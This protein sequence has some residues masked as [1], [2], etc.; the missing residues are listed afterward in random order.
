MKIGGIQKF[1]LID[2]PGK[3]SCVVFTQGCNFRCGYCHNP[4]LVLPEFF[5]NTI[6]EKIVF[7]YLLNRKNKIEGVV[8][9]GGEPTIHNDLPGFIKKIKMLG[10]NV[11]LD[12]NGGNP[13]MLKI[14]FE[15]KLL[16][17]VAMDV[18]TEL[19]NYS[20]LCGVNINSKAISESISLIKNSSV[21]RQ[22]RITLLK[23]IHDVDQITK[24]ENT[25][26]IKLH[27]QYFHFTTALL[28][29]KYNQSNS[30][31]L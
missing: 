5:E 15:E 29:K 20:K 10:F 14:L 6:D 17:F 31:Q 27:L 4:Q 1:S 11:K 19:E 25:F 26:G 13:K 28:S 18:K 7:E 3:I 24:I 30:Y 8:I 9:T 22:F 12:T 2:Y 23:G 21:E 16:D